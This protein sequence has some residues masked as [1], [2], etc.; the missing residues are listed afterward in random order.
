[1]SSTP[2][3]A[4]QTRLTRG[5]DQVV[6][7]E[8]PEQVSFSYTIA[9]I[10]SRAAAAIID[11]AVIV[12]A[13]LALVLF[14][15]L[16]LGGVP[17][18]A[19]A[20]RSGGWAV[21]LLVLVQFVVQ[22]GYYVLFEA[23]RD[24]Q[25]PGKRWLGLRVVQDGGYSVSFAASAARNIARILDMQPG[26]VYLTGLIAVW[27]SKT[28]K[29]LGDQ[30]AGTIV[31]R[32]RIITQPRPRRA[33]EQTRSA[34]RLGRAAAE[35][36]ALPPPASPVGVAQPAPTH[37]APAP[38]AALLREDELD[39]LE[40]FLARAESMS[41][42]RSDGLAR[43][44]AGRFRPHID[45]TAKPMQ[46]L[47]SLYD[48]ERAIRASGVAGRDAT[49]AA[50]ERYALLAEGEER[51]SRFAAKLA[52]TQLRGLRSLSA[53]EVA[54]FVAEY[55]EIATDL[56]RLSTATRGGDADAVFRLSRLVA[57]GHN[58][59][60]R[61]KRV[62][63]RAIA[64]FLLVDVPA[65]LRRSAG[66]IA[67]AAVLFFGSGA[68]AYLAV[69]RDPDMAEALVPA[70][71]I[72]R[73]EADAARAAAG[74]ATYIDVNEYARPILATG[75]LRNNVQVA[76]IAFASGLTAGVFTLLLLVLNGISIGAVIGLF[77]AK[78]VRHLILD[79][80]TAHGPF[81]LTAICIAA[82]GGFLIAAAILLPGPITRRE[83]LVLQGRRALR[84]LAAATLFLVFAGFIEGLISP[85][86]D[87]GFPLKLTVAGV[88]L[89]AIAAYWSL[90]TRAR[91]VPMTATATTA[92]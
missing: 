29:R 2:L 60:Y 67:F 88:S 39:L 71:M 4:T 75:V 12:G 7:I 42:Q 82:G 15:A 8:T 37:A 18:T 31:V 35:T 89:L 40:R 46:A 25:T 26:I 47:R 13:L 43:Q 34:G 28:G 87:L 21:A 22:W 84:L 33:G 20:R 78:G 6:E 24:G 45:A 44:L 83:A 54:T 55:R 11:H 1:M 91:A 9:G 3:S 68:A 72:D 90:R 79:F 85:R 58:L 49:G 5:Y 53:D 52:D 66:A 56:A 73:A 65:E 61:Q 14:A 41:L 16:L 27:V 62:A 76:F 51:W 32:E 50:R 38:I 77:A 80:V 81:E 10:G 63:A 30:V 19:L 86:T 74:D 59:L 69:V 36:G 48:R 64:R 70:S 57:G 23:L 92:P 17:G